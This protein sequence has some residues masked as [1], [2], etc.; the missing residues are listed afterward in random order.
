MLKGRVG[1]RGER[2]FEGTV[3]CSRCG[4]VHAAVLREAEPRVVEVVVSWMG[5]SR[6][7]QVELGPEEI[8]K[9]GD[10]LE[11]EGNRVEVTAI[12]EPGGRRVGASLGK[13]ISTLWSKEVN[14][15][16]VRFSIN[17]G[18]RTV[19]QSLLA[20]PEEEFGVGDVVEVGRDRVL[21]HRIMKTTGA[22]LKEGRARAEEITRVYGRALRHG[23]TVPGEGHGPP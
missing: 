5:R 12:E 17:R 8:V 21:V 3:R 23:E 2:V 19:A 10:R 16:R 13:N 20:V 14:R 22:L 4:T 9:V 11:L 1:G 6:R 15:V 7:A 18:N